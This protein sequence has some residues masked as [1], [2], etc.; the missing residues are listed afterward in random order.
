MKRL[1][2][3]QD[4]RRQRGDQENAERRPKKMLRGG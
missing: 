4:K 3:G 2:G 1:S